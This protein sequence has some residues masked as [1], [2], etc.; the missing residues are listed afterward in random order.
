M[1]IQLSAPSLALALAAALG[2]SLAASDAGAQ[3]TD[4]AKKPAA[5]ARHA[6][7]AAP[8][9]KAVVPEAP[10]PEAD[11][12][13]ISAAE[14][15]YYG[16]YACE[17][18]GV[19]HIEA[20]AKYPA[21]VDV[22]YDKGLWVMKPV[23]SSTGAMRLEDIRGETLMVQISSK[24]MLLDVKT[25][26]RLVDDCVSP[27]QRELIEAARAAQAAEAASA[28]ADGRPAP[29]ESNPLK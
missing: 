14:K 5:H 28:A 2:M 7:K 16:T 22:K 18:N 29:V 10:P 20:N 25:G 11:A 9:K 17:F 19:V 13:Q 3:S 6:K 1:T 4:A 21:Y 12:A 26:H 15:V 27:K 24:S 23:L 8:A